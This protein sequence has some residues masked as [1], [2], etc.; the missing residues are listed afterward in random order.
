MLCV[1]VYMYWYYQKEL[2]WKHPTHRVLKKNRREENAERRSIEEKSKVNV[3]RPRQFFNFLTCLNALPA[4]F[5]HP[6]QSAPNMVCFLHFDLRMSLSLQRRAIF[7]FHSYLRTRRF[8]G[9]TFQSSRPTNQ[10]NSKTIRGVAHIL[11]EWLFFSSDSSFHPS[12]L[13]EVGL[14]NFLW[15][16]A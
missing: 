7:S 5:S 3:F 8:S 2:E 1:C 12:I 6:S 10:W 14:L 4:I 16:I 13:S 9:P 15:Q 11:R